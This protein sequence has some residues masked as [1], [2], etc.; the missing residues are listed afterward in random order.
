M[1][2]INHR[3]IQALLVPLVVSQM[4]IL[5]EDACLMNVGY[6]NLDMSGAYHDD[7]IDVL[8]I[9]S[10]E[11]HDVGGHSHD[12]VYGLFLGLLLQN[13]HKLSCLSTRVTWSYRLSQRI[14]DGPI[15]S[16][17]HR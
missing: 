12:V 6:Q 16:Q 10:S 9:L 4:V 17:T 13:L 3:S 8:Q 2:V 7:N 1:L 11:G 14:M 5:D 15:N